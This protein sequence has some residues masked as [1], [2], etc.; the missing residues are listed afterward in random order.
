MNP[1]KL[2]TPFVN[3]DATSQAFVL[4]AIDM[5]GLRTQ[6]HGG[7]YSAELPEELQEAGAEFGFQ[8]NQFEFAFDESS[9]DDTT[10]SVAPGTPLFDWLVRQLRT[11]SSVD[12]Q[13]ADQPTNVHEIS[14]RLFDCYEI[15]NGKAHL[16]GCT[17]EDRPILRLTFVE[18]E[19]ATLSHLYVHQ[20]G[21]PVA[22]SLIDELGLNK[23]AAQQSAPKLKESQRKVMEHE[24]QRQSMASERPI[25]QTLIWC[26]Y[27]EGKLVFVI[28]DAS[29]ELGFGEWAHHLASGITR[30]PAF[31]CQLTGRKSYRLAA[32]DDGQIT[33]AESIGVCAESGQRVLETELA[34]CNVTGKTVLKTS[35]QECPVTKNLILDVA[36]TSC[37]VCHQQVSQ[38][39]LEASVCSA[40]RSV[41]TVPKSDP[42]MARVLGEYN[43]LDRFRKW[44]ISE[45][46]T[47]YILVA[48]NFSERVLFVFEKETLAV[49]HAA[50]SG[51]WRKVWREMEKARRDE[52]LL[53]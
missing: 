53:G 5:L 26:K 3:C 43:K 24:A 21:S 9:H 35:L 32:T 34:S 22:T 4:W 40:C 6:A 10:C 41:S 46:E 18:A 42:R 20:D 38:E 31:H 47:A 7:K 51:R 48:T 36:M 1:P 52:L 16:A 8:D 39:A 12:A 2:Q 17:L 23:L 13:P 14:S 44:R 28:D 19:K 30:P 25:L 33:T 49:R 45:T 11:R 27:A 37:D 29:V 15:E 50:S